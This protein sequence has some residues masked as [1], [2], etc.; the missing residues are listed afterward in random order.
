[1][2]RSNLEIVFSLMPEQI[3][4]FSPFIFVFITVGVGLTVVRII[5]RMM[6][7]YDAP[8]VSSDVQTYQKK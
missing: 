1:M 2:K 5:V 3:N 6:V 4:S 7:G 8:F